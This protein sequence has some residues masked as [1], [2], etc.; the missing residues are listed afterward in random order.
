MRQK[1]G[2]TPTEEADNQQQVQRQTL[3]QRDGQLFS[4]V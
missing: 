2:Q 4:L 1:V 3:P